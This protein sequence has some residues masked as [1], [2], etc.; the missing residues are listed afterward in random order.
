[1]DMP[2]SAGSQMPKEPIRLTINGEL[3][4]LHSTLDNLQSEVQS[5]CNLADIVVGPVPAEALLEAGGGQEAR[6]PCLHRFDTLNSRFRSLVSQ[7]A[8]ERLR[9]ANGVE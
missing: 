1:M 6:P 2:Q 3:D 7:L 5:L 9:L 4:E 8:N